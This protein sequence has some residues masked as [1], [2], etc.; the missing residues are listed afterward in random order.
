MKKFPRDKYLSKLRPFYEDAGMLKIITG[1]RRCG[2]SCLLETIADELIAKGVS[3]DHII[4]IHLDKRTY[5][6]IKTASDLELAIDKLCINKEGTKYLFLD[7]IQNIVGFEEVVNAFR[8]EDEYS[9]FLT[10]SNSYLLSGELVTKLTGRYIEIRMTTLTFD[11]YLDMKKYLKKEIITNLDE[12]FALYIV[13][14]GFPKSLEY[15]DLSSKR[16]YVQSVIGEIFDKDIKHNRKI[17][18]KRLFDE[19]MRYIINNFGA[20]SSVGSLCDYLNASKKEKVRK[21]TVYRYI[22]QLENLRIVE[23]CTRLDQKSKKSLFGSEKYYLTDLSFY[24]LSNTDNRINYGPVLENIVYNY[25][26]SMN[27]QVS[28]GKIGKLEIDFVLRDQK[29][30][31]SYI[32]VAR[33]IINENY[34]NEGHNLTEE[35]E[36]RPL[37]TIKDNY[38]K[39]LLTMDRLIQKR[40]GIIHAN[41]VEFI[42][43]KKTF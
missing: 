17:R 18:K 38:P 1:V 31:Y 26:R 24:F 43:N 37:E 9:I 15:D 21:E 22:E 41:L 29:L 25:V 20:T 4:F 8:E 7:E 30:D 5:K 23:K 6:S 40:S 14:G 39:Y 19:I 11:E 34:D 35:R 3:Q 13:E 27:Y 28:I 36:Y 10:G 32:Q 2:K 12:E 33:T 42:A 16:T